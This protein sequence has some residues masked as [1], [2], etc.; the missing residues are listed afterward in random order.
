MSSRNFPQMSRRRAVLSDLGAALAQQM[1][2]WG[3]DAKHPDGNVLVHMGME[4]RETDQ[5]AGEGSSRYR[6]I[7]GGGIVELHSFSA[8]W[9]PPHGTGT[10]FIRHLGRIVGCSGGEPPSPGS[11]RLDHSSPDDLVTLVVPMIEWIL[12]YESGVKEHLGRSYREACF[13]HSLRMPGVRPWLE[14]EDGLKWLAEFVA[15]PSSVGRGRPHSRVN[16]L[17]A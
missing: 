15:D 14:P 4:R 10:V 16:A 3:C 8:G 6:A 2:Y 1:V 17:A 11:Y 13:R 5:S 9:Y 12:R 7:W